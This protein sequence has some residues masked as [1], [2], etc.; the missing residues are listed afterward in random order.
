MATTSQ[1][2]ETII[3]I[4]DADLRDGYFRFYTTKELD[5]NRLLKIAGD[6]LFS[7][8]KVT[9]TKDGLTTSWDCRVP[10]SFLQRRRWLIRKKRVI[11]PISEEKKAE[12]V[13]NL[14][15]RTKVI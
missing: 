1:D 12:M 14:R 8:T 4:N 11:P 6:S 9:Q 13:A 5:Y 7:P 3:L 15:K 2:N 10:V